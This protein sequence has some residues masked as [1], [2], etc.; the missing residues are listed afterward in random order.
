LIWNYFIK[1]FLFFLGK[2]YFLFLFTINPGRITCILTHIN[3]FISE[4]VF[5]LGERKWYPVKGEAERNLRVCLSRQ[6][7]NSNFESLMTESH[8]SWMTVLHCYIMWFHKSSGTKKLFI[9]ELV[10]S[11]GEMRSSRIQNCYTVIA[12]INIP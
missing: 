2:D 9:S 8:V 10:F 12:L 1:Y 6:W 5:S 4:L 3:T 11:L 7:L